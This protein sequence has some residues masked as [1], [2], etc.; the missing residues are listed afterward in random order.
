MTPKPTTPRGMADAAAPVR[1][2]LLPDAADARGTPRPALLV[3]GPCAGRPKPRAFPTIAAALA[4][5][6]NM[7]AAR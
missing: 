7:E 5:K 3:P 6:R 2:L 1:L 4:A